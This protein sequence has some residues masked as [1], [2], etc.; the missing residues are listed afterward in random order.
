MFSIV[1]QSQLA[2]DGDYDQVRCLSRVGTEGSERQRCRGYSSAMNDRLDALR[3]RL[4]AAVSPEVVLTRE[5]VG[6]VDRLRATRLLDDGSERYLV[7]TWTGSPDSP[8]GLDVFAILG[9]WYRNK[10]PSRDTD[11]RQWG[12]ADHTLKIVV[13]WLV[14]LRNEWTSLPRS[15]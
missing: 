14:D 8:L 2:L 12:N 3:E 4:I 9:G 10:D 1:T 7:I 6:G 15:D 13:Q 11:G 5:D